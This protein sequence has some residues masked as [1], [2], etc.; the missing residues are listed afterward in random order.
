[1]A[2]DDRDEAIR[3]AAYASKSRQIILKQHLK[4]GAA[5]LRLEGSLIQQLGDTTKEF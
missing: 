4:A 2:G 5:T 3:V 1:V